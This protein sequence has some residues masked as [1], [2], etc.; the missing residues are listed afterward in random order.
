[1]DF[2]NAV[3]L[4]PMAGITH[5]P[6]RLLAKSYECDIVCSEMVSASGIIFNSKNTKRLLDSKIEEK[7]VS[8]QIFGS[9]PSIMAD[10]AQI[11]EGLGA[12]IIDI[13]FG[14]SVKKI[15]KTGAG[16][17]LMKEPEKAEAVI[18]AVKKA[19]KIPL[20]IKTRTGWDSSGME[21]FRLSEIAESLG[22]NA[23]CVHPRTAK[24]GFSGKSD[25][26]I[27]TEVKK[28]V[29]IPVIGNGDIVTP[30]D[31]FDMKQK[32]GCNAVMVGRAAIGNPW[33]FSQ[34]KEIMTGKEVLP[35]SL[36]DRMETVKKYIDMLINYFGDKKA[37]FMM[38][39]QLAPFLKGFQYSSKARE[40][41]T[42]I[43]SR[44]EAIAVLDS[45]VTS[46]KILQL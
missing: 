8:I 37:C 6:F 44:D 45:Y 12:D 46:Q 42:H 33:I 21:L 13:N 2:N 41:I 43:S 18:C 10:A 16:V 24:Q 15:V 17:A 28:K 1:M 14:C 30:K 23:I 34:I 22:V 39:S 29:K 20:T 40:Q 7:P 32:T 31:A 38:R 36:Y 3:I 35:V 9:I 25:W 26:S 27:I 19:V 11:I 4:A 5:L